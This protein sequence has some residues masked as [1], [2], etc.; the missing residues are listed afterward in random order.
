[1]KIALVTVLYKSEEMLA[2]FLKSLSIQYFRDFHLYFIDNHPQAHAKA[3]LQQLL[4]KYSIPHYTYLSNI[5]N[6]GVAAANNQGIEASL[7]GKYTHTL[8][9]NNDIVFTDPHLLG[10]LYQE[11]IQRKLALVVPKIWYYGTQK[12]WMAGGIL[13]TKRA[14]TEHMGDLQEDGPEYNHARFV[15]Y[16]PTCF[17]LIDNEVF[18]K[19]GVMR[20]EYFVYYDD[21][22]FLFRAVKRGYQVYYMPQLGIWHKVSAAT[23]GTQ[24]LFSIYYMARNRLFF[25]RK[26]YFGT[27][28][29]VAIALSIIDNLRIAR[30][31]YNFQQW[32]MVLKGLWHGLV[33]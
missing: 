32:K 9:L 17:M 24:S 22:D 20:P 8:L 29:V 25:V 7:A 31:Y 21:T 11:A 4:Q 2:D 18:R 28:F 3:R 6:V 16:A 19:I 1:M 10:T 33:K 15:N 26:N 12:I 30:R 27:R 5:R 23:G 13:H 14:L